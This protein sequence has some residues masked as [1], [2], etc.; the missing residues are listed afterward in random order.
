MKK[1]FLSMLITLLLLTG[2]GKVP[3]LSNGQE[4]VLSLKDGGIS[5]DELYQRMKKSYALNVLIDMMDEKILG[6]K[7]PETDEEKK[8]VSDF[9]DQEHL[10]IHIY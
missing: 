7:Y 2:C 4:A 5:V 6:P 8:Y 10:M 9:V 3:V 1:I